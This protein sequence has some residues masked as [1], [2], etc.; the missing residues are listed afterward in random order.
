MSQGEISGGARPYN[1]HGKGAEGKQ[2][3]GVARRS[4]EVW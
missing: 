1:R 3:D 4:E 2:D